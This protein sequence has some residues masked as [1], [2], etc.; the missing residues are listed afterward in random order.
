MSKQ[1]Y[2]IIGTGALGGLYGGLLARA[3]F[4]VHFLAHRDFEHLRDHGLKVESPLGDFHL[5][6]V[7]VHNSP[8]TMPPC[9]VTIV[10][11][12]TTQNRLLEQLLPAPT[13]QGGLVLVLQNGLDVEAD[14]ARV[15]GF[16]RILGGCCFLCSNKVGPGH[17]RHLDYGAIVFGEYRPHT[18]SSNSNA[19]S[20]DR[21]V[22]VTERAERIA[23]E[24]VSAG[25]DANAT[26]DLLTARWRKLMWNIPFNGLSVVLD[27]STKE[28]MDH[29]DSLGL[30]ETIIEE[31]Y[32]AALALGVP[33]TSEMAHKT[34]E[35]TR[36]M[37]PYDASM[38][39]DYRYQRPME[40][41][42]IFGNP[43]RAAAAVHAPMPAVQML[44]RQLKFL[45]ARNLSARSSDGADEE[46]NRGGR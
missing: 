22:G 9:D 38:R 35:V 41:E 5:A 17:I 27:A 15:V 24:M 10:A 46:L 4:E 8:E 26:P 42:A 6:P 19:T 34:V 20:K 13:R 7:S 21:L 33:V 30:V 40:V 39:L 32:H 31:V 37:V 2:A 14:A 18:G 36:K 43:L 44:Y 23:R 29:P 25:I 45:D 16:D 3:G 11:L 1:R 12:K 28:L